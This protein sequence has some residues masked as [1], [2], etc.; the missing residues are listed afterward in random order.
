MSEALGTE[1]RALFTALRQAVDPAILAEIEQFVAAADDAELCRINVLDFA[2][3]RGLDADRTIAAFLH[4]ARLGIFVLSWN[5]LCRSCGGVLDTETSL[6]G[7]NRPEYSCAFCAVGCEPVLD[8]LVE[9]TFTVTRRVRRIAAHE[10]HELP[11]WDYYRQIFFSSG[12]DLPDDLERQVDE[13]T[14][15]T[16]ELAPGEKAS[17]SMQLPATFA[18][19]FD[20]VSHTA[21][22]LDVQGEP[23]R[24]RQNLSLV[25][26]IVPVPPARMQIRPGPVRLSLENHCDQRVLPTVWIADER[27][28]H[29]L[30]QRKPFLNA[31]RL[32]TN[33]TFRE[34]Y[35]NDTIDANQRLKITSM[36][37]LFTDLRGSTDLYER[38][39]DL[40]AFELVRAHFHVMQEIVAAEAGAVVKTIGD[41]VM[42]TFPTP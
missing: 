25:M 17:L 27:L 9:V 8:D 37:F 26:D 6:K 30:T 16:I 11:I 40:A 2:A 39:G 23:T 35:G 31:K 5:V 15:D 38:I 13:L 22:F 14:L 21:L 20:P 10:P 4:A 32:L 29:L 41:A 18:I 28:E 12:I 7:I 36:T 42:A 1:A 34:L 24:E 3:R 19:L 33:Q